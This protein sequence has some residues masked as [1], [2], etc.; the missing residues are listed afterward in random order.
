MGPRPTYPLN[1]GHV[2][3]PTRFRRVKP[4]DPRRSTHTSGWPD[5]I[6]VRQVSDEERLAAKALAGEAID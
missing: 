5:L 6:F 4:M 1:S 3:A 2:T